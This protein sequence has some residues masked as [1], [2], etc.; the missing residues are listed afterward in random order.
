MPILLLDEMAQALRRTPAPMVYRQ[1]W[2]RIKLPAASLTLS[3]KLAIIEQYVGKKVIDAVVGT[4]SGC[5]RRYR[6]R[7]GQEC[8][9]PAISIA[10]TASYC[11]VRWR[12]RCRR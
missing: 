12:K 4:E 1:S 6:P 5:F 11:I 9:K 8:W 10:M 2:A 7:C 3:D